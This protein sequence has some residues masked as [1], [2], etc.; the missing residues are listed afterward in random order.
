MYTE[1]ERERFSEKV[2]VNPLT[3]CH[4]WTAARSC[5]YGRVRIRGALHVASR[6]SYEMYVGTIPDGKFVCHACDNPACVNPDH[7]FV[8]S[9]KDNTTDAV[10]KGRISGFASISEDTRGRAVAAAYSAGVRLSQLVE[11]FGISSRSVVIMA[12][13]HG[14]P[15]RPKARPAGWT[16]A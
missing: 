11:D 12:R 13:R 7:L 8:G 4:E 9:P 10:R 1:Q 6:V 15:V 16:L 14:V 5:G 3:G 2:Q